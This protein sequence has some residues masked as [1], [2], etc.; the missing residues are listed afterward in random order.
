MPC[1]VSTEKYEMGQDLAFI[2]IFQLPIQVLGTV[3]IGRWCTGVKP[4]SP[5]LLGYK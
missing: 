3:V 4:L 1:V 2:A 5:Y